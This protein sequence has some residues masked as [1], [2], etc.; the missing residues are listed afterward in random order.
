MKTETKKSGASNHTRTAQRTDDHSS[1]DKSI[2]AEK[3]LCVTGCVFM[4]TGLLLVFLAAAGTDGRMETPG[5]LVLGISGLFTAVLG[6]V[7]ISMRKVVS[8]DD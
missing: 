1:S 8:K 2:I 4:L 7:L 5:I 3:I 6:M